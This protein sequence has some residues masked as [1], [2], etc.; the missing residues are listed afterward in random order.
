[1]MA[2][3]RLSSKSGRPVFTFAALQGPNR[4]VTVNFSELSIPFHLIP[5]ALLPFLP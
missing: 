5:L 2:A 4:F 1:M 3:W